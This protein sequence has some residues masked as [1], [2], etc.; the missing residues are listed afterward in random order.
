MRR[1]LSVREVE[2][3]D[4][5]ARVEQRA[6]P[7]LAPALWPVECGCKGK[8]TCLCTVRVASAWL[9]LMRGDRAGSMAEMGLV[10][11]VGR[12]LTPSC[13]PPWSSGASAAPSGSY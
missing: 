7:L 3:S 1:V 9:G 8:R 12:G 2:A 11:V 13:R 4:A 5:E 6:Q 10:G